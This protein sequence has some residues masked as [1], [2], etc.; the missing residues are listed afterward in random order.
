MGRV[1]WQGEQFFNDIRDRAAA[2]MGDA[3]QEGVAAAKDR[4]TVLTGNYRDHWEAGEIEVRGDVVHG[5]IINEAQNSSGGFYGGY[6]SAGTTRMT[7]DFAHIAAL[8]AAG[9][10]LVAGL[11]DIA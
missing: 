10:A 4:S 1:D 11:R 8:D 9:V 7:G 5:E 6:R 3:L 2:V